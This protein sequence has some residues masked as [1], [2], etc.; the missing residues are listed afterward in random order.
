VGEATARKDTRQVNWRTG[1][2]S[3]A[4]ALLSFFVFPGHTY[5]QEDTQIY[6]PILEHLRD[7]NVL[8]NDILV[9]QH[10][11]AFTLYDETARL[12]RAATG[13]GFREVLTAQ[14]V[15]TR[16]LGVWGLLLIGQSLEMATPWLLP[17]I[18]M[19]GATISGPAVLT[20]EYEPTPRAFAL[21]LV[22]CAIGLTAK[23]RYRGAA[24]AASAAFL[25][26]P[27]TA[28][29]FWVVFCGLMVYRREWRALIPLALSAAV[30]VLAARGQGA[31]LLATLGPLQERLQRF[32]APYLWLSMW[33]DG[34]ALMYGALA[35]L[36]LAAYW[37]VRGKVPADLRAV[38]VGL[39]SIGLLSM[40]LSSA[41]LEG[42]HLAFVSKFQPMRAVLFVEL[43]MQ[44]LAVAAGAAAVSERK[45]PR[46]FLWFV[47]AYLF[48]VRPLG[49]DPV[50]SQEV[51]LV[52]G[53][54]VVTVAARKWAP[55]A[56]VAAYFA[57]PMLGGVRNYSRL[58]TPELAEL[59]GWART[60]TPRDAVFLFPD[61]GTGRE[62]G[63]FRAE[64][65]RA[66]YVDWKGGGQVNFLPDFSA[67]WWFRWQQTL[68]R[69]FQ[70]TEF[71]RYD[72]LGIQYVVLPK[73]YSLAQAPVFENAR[74][75]VYTPKP[76]F[77]MR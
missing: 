45:W 70:D 34:V 59:S 36:A 28:I 16:A 35:V 22:F 48:A 25:Y 1:A 62:P 33:P 74:Y 60:A 50:T 37:R 54:A 11:V 46:A 19:L 15:A 56:A 66:V 51:M 18:C 23:G 55:A 38:L 68:E 44:I 14:Q 42:R 76:D 12:L 24:V 4:I 52:L 21:P 5:L 41:L 29:P 65:L 43:A 17:L 9:Q 73:G 3:L 63:M 13:L 57:I 7:P 67:Q 32:R 75:A 71:P 53:L 27:P 58:E 39:V 72:A 61:A 40:P 6:V 2:A 31:G 30:L 8:R 69:G 64:A 49:I 26:H 10:H 20:V 77:H 47:L